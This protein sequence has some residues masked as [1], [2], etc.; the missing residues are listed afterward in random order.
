[1]LPETDWNAQ[2]DGN[3]VLDSITVVGSG[4]LSAGQ[5]MYL[6]CTLPRIVSLMSHNGA[7][8]DSMVT[9]IARTDPTMTREQVIAVR[10]RRVELARAHAF[11]YRTDDQIARAAEEARR[12][13]TANQ[14]PDTSTYNGC[15]TVDMKVVS[16]SMASRQAEIEAATQRND[17]AKLTEIS[18]HIMALQQKAQQKCAHLL[19]Q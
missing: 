11:G 5:W 8:D 12:Q 2:R 15:L 6:G 9:A 18:N 7:V 13:E 14:G 3:A 17:I 10:A 4:G 19:N 16:D 1:V